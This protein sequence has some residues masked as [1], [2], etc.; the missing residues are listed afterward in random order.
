MWSKTLPSRY[1]DMVARSPGERGNLLQA[2]PARA[3]RRRRTR[4]HPCRMSWSSTRR[5][6]RSASYL[7]AARSSSSSRTRQSASRSQAPICTAQASPS[8]HPAWS[9]SSVSCGFL[10]GDPF[11]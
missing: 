3:T 8:P 4:R 6:S 2:A 5:T 1:R 7:S 10:T 9:G 11:L